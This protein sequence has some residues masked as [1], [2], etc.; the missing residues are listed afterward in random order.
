MSPADLDSRCLGQAPEPPGGCMPVHP[1]A[2]AVK[3][4]RPA[5]TVIHGAID[6]PADRGGQRNQDDFAAFAADPQDPVA[7]L[8][9]EIADVRARGLEDSQAQQPQHGTKAKSFRLA[10]WRAAVSRASNCRWVNPRVGDSAGTAG[11]R[12]CSAGE[13]SRTPSITQVR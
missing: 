13:Y 2:V 6:R 9:A 4:D 7:V 3:Q 11:R 5:V 1:P 10:D 12:T 8:L